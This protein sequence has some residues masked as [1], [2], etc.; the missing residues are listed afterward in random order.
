MDSEYYTNEVIEYQEGKEIEWAIAA[1]K[2]SAVMEA[3]HA[4]PEAQWKPFKTRYGDATDREIA[5][6]VHVMNKGK[7]AKSL[8]V[9]RWK[10]RQGELFNETCCYHC[11]ATNMEKQETEVVWD[12]NERA[13]IE[14]VIKEIKGGFDME[15][16]PSGDF[17]ANAIYFAIGIMTYNLFVAQKLFTMPY[18]WVNK[19]IKGINGGF[20]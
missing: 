6:T 15:G 1:D 13:L 16:M 4:I 3:I 2:D 5:K 19:T 20:W 8:I 14:N 10:D 9:M 17:K 12:Y 18:E 11:I 7:K